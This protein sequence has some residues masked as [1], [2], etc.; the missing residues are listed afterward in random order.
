[1]RSQRV[2]T[3]MPIFR[4]IRSP[5]LPHL[6]ICILNH[7]HNHNHN[8]ICSAIIIK[9]SFTSAA[10]LRR[11]SLPPRLTFNENELEESFIRGSGPGGQKIVRSPLVFPICVYHLPPFSPSPFVSPSFILH[12]AYLSPPSLVSSPPLSSQSTSPSQHLKTNTFGLSTP[13]PQ[14]EQNLLRSSAPPHSFRPN[15]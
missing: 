8:R 9:R 2:I 10:S 6:R 1:M 3:P 12:I 13:P 5:P 15:G 14:P 7:N 4:I 11:K